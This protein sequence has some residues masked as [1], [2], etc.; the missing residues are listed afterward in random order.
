MES[1]Q[2]VELEQRYISAN[3]IRLHVTFAGPADGPPILLLRGFPEFWYGWRHQIP[4]LAREGYRVIVPDQRGY[5]LSDAPPKVRDYDL[6]ILA[7]EAIQL[8]KTLGYE[9]VYVVG[10]DWGGLVAWQSAI[11]YPQHIRKL[12]ILNV[13]H[14]DVISG[15]L[16]RN[17]KQIARSWYV[18]AFQLPYLGEWLGPRLARLI[19]ATA[20]EGSFTRQDIA[21]YKAS[22]DTVGTFRGM[23][24]WYRAIY[25]KGLWQILSSLRRRQNPYQ[26]FLPA[27]V[28]VPTRVLWGE[29]DIALEASVG[30]RSIDYCDDGQ[31]VAFPQA[32]HWLQHDEPEA[33]N[34]FLAS[35]LKEEGGAKP[36]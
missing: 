12:V 19:F 22:W 23:V 1:L 15:A 25:R 9:S 2:G 11:N 26:L 30:H 33:V 10:H 3:N 8:I 14:P 24:N 5:H 16:I 20:R 4:Y 27:R 6:N 7:E 18:L 36:P 21:L 32:S 13:P 28:T 35:F 29:K 34:R 17:V 31:F